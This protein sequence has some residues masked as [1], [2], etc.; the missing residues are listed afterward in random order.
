MDFYSA[1]VYHMLDIHMLLYT[2]I[3]A[4]SRIVGYSA[5]ILE[6]YANN[7]II[8]P[9]CNYIGNMDRGFVPIEDR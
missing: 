3:F 4:L 9:T 6:Q 5:H 2:P 1:P 7:K 8:R